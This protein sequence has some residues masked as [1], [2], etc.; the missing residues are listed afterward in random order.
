[1][2]GLTDNV[3]LALQPDTYADA[4]QQGWYYRKELV[5][6]GY[7]TRLRVQYAT[8]PPEPPGTVSV[9]RS[10]LLVEEREVSRHIDPQ[11]ETRR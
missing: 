7:A 5:V 2:E 4:E 3:A 8:A 10:P 11:K 9:S 1:M 6:S